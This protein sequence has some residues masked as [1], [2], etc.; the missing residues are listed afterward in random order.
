M[1]DSPDTV[2]L[3]VIRGLSDTEGSSDIRGSSETIRVSS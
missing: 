3:A 1:A 2:A